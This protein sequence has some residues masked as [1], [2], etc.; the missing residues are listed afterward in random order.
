[1]SIKTFVQA[2]P[3]AD[4]NVSLEGAVRKETWLKIAQQNERPEPLKDFENWIQLLEKP[5]YTQLEELF[6]SVREWLVY[7]DDIT[8]MVYDVGV[9]LSKQKIKY[10]EVNVSP[11]T[12][13]LRACSFCSLNI[14]GLFFNIFNAIHRSTTP[15][16]RPTPIFTPVRFR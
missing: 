5:D 11:A 3:K 12:I 15:P 2:M 9:T 13:E 14:E 6:E 1:M 16:A 7:P 10:A 8:R 4:I